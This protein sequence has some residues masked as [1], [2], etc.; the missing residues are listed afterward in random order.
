R[1]LKLQERESRIQRQVQLAA[2]V[3]QRMLPRRLPSLPRLDAAARYVPSFELGGDFYDFIELER[4]LG[5][6]IG[7]VVGKGIAAALLMS[8][9]RASLR[10]HVQDIYHID[11]VLSRVNAAL[12][13]DTLD[14][15]FATLWYGVVDTEKLRFTYCSGGHEPPLVFR[16]VKGRPPAAADI[17]ELSIGGMAVGID[18]TQRYQRGTYDLHPGDVIL[19]YTD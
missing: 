10:A 2:D 1:L 19:A 13:R 18:P 6:A 3:Q 15:E 4:N 8:A 11:D 12:C 17:D 9:V 5:I 7:D 14:N 16:A